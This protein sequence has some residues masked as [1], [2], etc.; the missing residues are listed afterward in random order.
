[1]RIGALAIAVLAVLPAGAALAQVFPDP[2]VFRAACIA[3]SHRGL[4]EVTRD[5][6]KQDFEGAISGDYAAQRNVAFCLTSGCDGAI[7]VDRVEGCAWRMVIQGSEGRKEPTER[8]SFVGA[9]GSL[10]N[11][12]RRSALS[13]AEDMF[14]AIYGKDLP[15]DRLFTK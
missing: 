3:T 5:S 12:E 9:C 10:P 7:L 8:Q 4:C 14:S 11:S 1:M 13:R 2:G 15:L 6:F